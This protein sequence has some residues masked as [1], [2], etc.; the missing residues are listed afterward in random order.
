MPVYRLPSEIAFPDPRLAE[1]DGLVAVGGDL[2]PERLV[3]AYAAGIFPWYSQGEP[4]LWWSPD[5]RFVLDP[6]RVHLP[7]SLRRTLRR[8][9]YE[10]TA[11]RDFDAVIRRCG[12]RR[13]PGQRGTWITPAMRRA[14]GGLARLGLAH[15]IEARIDGRLAGGLYGVSLGGMFFG[16]SMFADE[17]DASKAAF[18]RL[19]EVLA[20]WDFD[21]VDC[22]LP[23]AHLLRFGAFGMPRAEFLERLGASLGKPHRQ[24]AWTL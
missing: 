6:A 4:L 14:Y 23:T 15:S 3:G 1:A 11:D 2:S 10:I 22:Q 8:G 24:G 5:P 7:R 21:L 19:C 17:P 13:R 20:S 16:E 9:T 12:A 18:A